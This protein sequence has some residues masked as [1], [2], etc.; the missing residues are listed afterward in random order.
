M[1]SVYYH[2]AQTAFGYA[3]YAF[4][5]TPVFKLKRV[6]LP[7]SDKTFISSHAQSMGWRDGGQHSTADEIG[8]AIKGYFTG[9]KLIAQW[10]W[11]DGDKWTTIQTAV[12]R[13]V[14]GIP[15]GEVR[16]Y[17]Q[18]A[19]HIGRPRAARFIGN[20]MANNPYP[21]LIPCHRVIRNDGRLGGFGGGSA[22]K[23]KMLDLEG[24]QNG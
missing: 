12:Y 21:I 23:Q 15:Y 3:A 18:I 24:L 14:A 16:S 8:Y 1:S 2:I 13:A 20:C 9:K 6:L 7:R 17:S 4:V 10:K 11:M 22:L 19:R 5:V